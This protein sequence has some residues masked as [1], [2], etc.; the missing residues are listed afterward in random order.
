MQELRVQQ[1][2]L[3]TNFTGNSF[4]SY[5]EFKACAHFVSL[6]SYSTLHVSVCTCS[7]LH[8]SNSFAVQGFHLIF[9]ENILYFGHKVH[10]SKK[11]KKSSD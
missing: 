8:I 11:V 4:Y 3:E 7:N 2:K 5:L 9:H 6:R 1:N 10:N